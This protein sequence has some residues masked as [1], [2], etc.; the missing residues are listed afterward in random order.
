MGIAASRAALRDKTSVD[1]RA[2]LQL[3]KPT[4]SMLVVFTAWPALFMAADGLPSIGIFIACSIGILFASGSAA[5][6]NHLVDS[7]IDAS[8]DRTSKRPLPSG[9]AT[10]SQCL[11]FSL[12]LGIVSF[13]LL[14]YF[15]GSL[16]AWLSVG[17]NFFYVVI[18]TMFLKRRTPQNIVIG[19][20]AGAV[21]PLIGW[22]S[23]TG[24]LSWEAWIMFAI[25]FLWTPPHFWA[26]ALKY[27][28]DYARVGVPMLP[29]VRGESHTRLQILLYS[30]SLLP[31]VCSLFVWGEAGEIY[32]YLALAAT[33]I[34]CILAFRLWWR[35][36]IEF[37]MPVFFFSLAYIFIIYGAL[38][39]DQ[40][41]LK[42]GFLN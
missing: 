5:V 35:R 29:N 3:T 20:T 14:Y 9:R 28:D 16:A 34:F 2:L 30:L 36:S 8:M 7:D 12:T 22:A 27:K 39:V 18:Y 24:G 1:F 6:L 32:A 10:P 26:L 40:F 21:G 11:A 31:F 42:S 41:F 33:V 38:A 13:Y 19:G 37:A 23:V 4:I 25:I 15:C 17:A